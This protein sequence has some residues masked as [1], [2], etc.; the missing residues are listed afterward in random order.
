MGDGELDRV[1]AGEIGGVERVL[2]ARPPLRFLAEHRRERV[3]HRVEDGDGMDAP[4]PRFLLEL[5]ADVAVHQRVEDE[6]RT[7]LDVV[8]NSV[9]MTLRAHHRPEMTK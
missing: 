3:H 2:A 6:P 4:P 5:A 9:E 1:D 8:E 7:P